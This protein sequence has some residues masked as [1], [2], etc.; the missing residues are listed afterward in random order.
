LAREAPEL[1][2]E[3]ESQLLE[4]FHDFQIVDLRR[5]KRTAYEKVWFIRRLL[6]AVAKSPNDITAEDLRLLENA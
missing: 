6:E 3:N 1:P 2:S 4:R 5:N